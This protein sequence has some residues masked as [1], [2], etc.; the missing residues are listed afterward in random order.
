MPK[1]SQLPVA[2]V[3]NTTDLFA[4]VQAGVTK[5]A[6]ESLV[7]ANIQA[8]I[9]I[10]TSQVTGLGT[11]ATVNV[12]IS[13]PN[14]G[15]GVA[16]PTAHTLP[17]AEGASNYNFVG[18]LTNGQLLIGST[19]LDPV[20]AAITAGSGISISNTAGGI[21]ITASGSGAFNWTVV[22]AATQTMAANNGYIANRGTAVTFT[23][24]AT[25]NVGDEIDLI[26]QGAGGWII[27]QP[28]GVNIQF[29]TK[30]TTVGVGGSLASTQRRDVVTMICT[31]A[32]TEWTVYSAVGNLTVV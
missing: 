15:T 29:G 17:V 25:A 20:A 7:L 8:N 3:V 23:L 5:Q 9:Q 28:A 31:T 21:T 16:S 30:A 26:G 32:N 10:T 14:G 24:P 4:I 1:I 19:G 27:A 6:T 12:P 18:P 2:S 22:T 13:A 11:A